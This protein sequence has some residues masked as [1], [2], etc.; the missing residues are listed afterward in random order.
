LVPLVEISKIKLLT[1]FKRVFSNDKRRNELIDDLKD[2]KIGNDNRKRYY[3]IETKSDLTYF[4][5]VLFVEL[6]T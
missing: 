6:L 4:G 1:S 2:K 5:Q 3:N